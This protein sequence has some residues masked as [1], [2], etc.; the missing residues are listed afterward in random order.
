MEGSQDT[1]I[2]VKGIR[3]GILLGLGDEPSSFAD[4]LRR[5]QRELAGK[6]SFLR[7]SRIVLDLGRRPL[8]Q[9]QLAEIQTLLT[10]NELELW[11]VLA[12]PEVTRE[13]A[14]ALGLA[15]RLAGSNT[16]LDGNELAGA[17]HSAPLADDDGR[18]GGSNTLMLFETL[19]SGRSVY[20]EGHVTIIGDV[21]PGAEVIAAGHVVVWGR[22]RGLVHAGALGDAS[23]VICAL[24]LAPTQLRIANTIAIAPEGPPA[25]AAPEMAAIRDGQIVAEPWRTKERE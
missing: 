13:A 7:G 4:L 11:T 3:D 8:Q 21:N 16:D 24:Q 23:A 17:E 12:E 2:Q 15:T 6:R 20:H 19:R 18:G 14:R 9:G 25:T 5:L 22:L 1:G 10:E